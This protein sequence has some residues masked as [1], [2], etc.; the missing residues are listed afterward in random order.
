MLVTGLLSVLRMVQLL[1]ERQKKGVL[2]KLKEAVSSFDLMRQDE[3]DIYTA[4]V[5]IKELHEFLTIEEAKVVSEPLEL[6]ALYT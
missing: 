5:S 3:P 1:R 2:E 6:S 4:P